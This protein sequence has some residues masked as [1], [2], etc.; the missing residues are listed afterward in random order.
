[1]ISRTTTSTKVSV[2][3]FHK[4]PLNAGSR[5]RQLL[6]TVVLD[7]FAPNSLGSFRMKA[8]DTGLASVWQIDADT[9]TLVEEI[10]RKRCTT[11]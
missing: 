10:H 1:M 11:R 5:I 7:A 3:S 6:S 8:S 9:T 4:S 2:G